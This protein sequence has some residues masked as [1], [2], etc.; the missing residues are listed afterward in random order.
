MN[1]RLQAVR[2]FGQGIWLD[3][4]SRELWQSGALKQWIEQDGIAGVTSNP[5]IFHKAIANDAL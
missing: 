1:S 2:A 3:N 4:L 5:A